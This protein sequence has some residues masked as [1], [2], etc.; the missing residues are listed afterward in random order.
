MK[1][2]ENGE[3]RSFLADKLEAFFKLIK[4]DWKRTNVSAFVVFRSMEGKQSIQEV[5]D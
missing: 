4:Y 1:A 5:Y 3:D 2:A